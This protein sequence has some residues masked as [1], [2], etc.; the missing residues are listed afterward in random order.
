MAVNIPLTKPDVYVLWTILILGIAKYYYV[1]HNASPVN[2]TEPQDVPTYAGFTPL[3]SNY[4]VGAHPS[5][6][7]IWWSQSQNC[8]TGYS[9]VVNR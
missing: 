1:Y 8:D 6:P 2:P 9:M 4:T 3:P 5:V 7:H